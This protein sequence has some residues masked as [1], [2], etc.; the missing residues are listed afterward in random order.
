MDS[1]MKTSGPCVVLAGAGTGKTRLMVEKVRHIIQNEIYAPE[2]IVCITFSNEAANNLASRIRSALPS[3]GKE[4]IVR[5]FH[6]FSSMLLKEYGEKIGVK[7]TFQTLT[8][9]DA[10]ILIHTNLRVPPMN[11]HRYIDSIGKAK[12]LGVSVGELKKYISDKTA[13]KTIS[14]LKEE[15]E[16]LQTE[17]LREQ[18]KEMKK[19]ISKELFRIKELV[20]LTRFAV[21]F[22]AYDKIKEQRGFLDYSDLNN[23]ALE[24]LEKNQELTKNFDYVIV[25]EFQDTNKVQLEF[26]RLLCPHKN[27]TVVGDMNQSIYRFRGAYEA[28]IDAFKKIFGVSQTDIFTLEK[29]YRSPEKILKAA[30][31]II[32]NNYTSEEGCFFVRN[33]FNRIGDNIKVIELKNGREEARKVVEIVREKIG[34]GEAAEEICVMAR[35]HQ[36]LAV[37]RKSLADAGIAFHSVGQE[38]LLKQNSI[39][40]IISYLTIVSN[41]VEK[42]NSGWSSWWDLVH[43]EKF[44]KGDF[45]E[46]TKFLKENREGENYNAKIFS[47]LENIKL[48]DEGA[49]KVKALIMKIKE[50]IPENGKELDELIKKTFDVCGFSS[51]EFASGDREAL[52]NVNKFQEFAKKYSEMHAGKLKDFVAHVEVLNVLGIAV[53]A[54]RIEDRGVRL[55]T[56]HSTKGLEYKTVILTNM[57]QK[58]FP[59]ERI[60]KNKFLPDELVKRDEEI[61]NLEEY[62][63]RNQ[64]FEERRLCY[65]SFTRSKSELIVT[66]AQEYAGKD[67][68]PSQFLEEIHYRDNPEID[69]VQDLEEKAEEFVE[70]KSA[71]EDGSLPIKEKVLSPSALNLFEECQKKF[72]YKY[73]YNM[74]DKITT[75]WEAIK[76]GSFIHFVLEQGV[77][78]N[79]R[80]LEDFVNLAK[81]LKN[82]EEWESVELDEVLPLIKVFFERNKDK[83]SGKSLTEK[84]L[85]TKISDLEFMGVADRIDFLPDGLEIVDYKTGKTVPSGKS[86]NWQLGYYAL[87]ARSLG[88]VKKMTLEVLQNDVPVEFLVKENGDVVSVSSNRVAFNLHEVE[89][90]L[91]EVGA[92]IKNAY[93]HGFKPCPPE[94][95]CEFCNEYVY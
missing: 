63:I 14:E 44:E 24:L 48:S 71:G 89:A 31:Q 17:F 60:S 52:L 47:S 6:S 72:E 15:L 93:A 53:E 45:I 5:T 95:N 79:F 38:S 33:A 21:V 73:V 11:C 35:T 69:F 75:S 57:A 37:I 41:L 77:K 22:E 54:A 65:V 49:V 29:S 42:N 94:K 3:L 66:Y 86:R 70:F 61:E 20:E 34:N 9:D 84:K 91:S 80:K 1:L 12:D 36:Q 85:F 39:K 18:N 76:M 8:P 26:L 10:K 59:I 16:I 43:E 19:K 74:P 88:N 50:L 32:R 56:A 40:K 28:N 78:N 64:M 46:I 68:A 2:K 92:R 7:K 25:D 23:K 83:Y 4:P 58:R 87:A 55:M 27:I 82:N 51:E 30:H 67:F 81:D 13:G 62:E 90:E